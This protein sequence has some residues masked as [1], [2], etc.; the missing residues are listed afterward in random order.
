MKITRVDSN[1]IG[2]PYEHAAPKSPLP[3]AQGRTTQD[4]VYVRVETDAG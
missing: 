1:F 3:T 4:A 2:I